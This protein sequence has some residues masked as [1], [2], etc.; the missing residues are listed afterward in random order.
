MPLSDAAIGRL[1]W[2]AIALAAFALLYALGPVLTP[3]FLAAILAYIFQ[4]LVL[5]LARR[6]PRALAVALVMLLEFLLLALLVLTVLPL[7]IKEI[8]LL[9]EQA[10]GF[11]DWLNHSL[12]PWIF[13]KTGVAVNFDAASLKRMLIDN[14]QGSEGLGM[15]LLNS[16]RMGGL[17]LV[18]IVAN[19]VLV[20]VVQFYLM[21]D[22]K[23]MIARVERLLPRPWQKD[24]IGF[25][26]EA[27]AALSQYL[28]GQVLVI[29]AM[30]LFYTGGLWVS[31]LAF[32][33]PI[34]MITGL[35]VFVPYL[36]AAI[37]L[38]LGTLAALM[39]FQEWS[40][41]LW[42]WLVFGIGMA[43][44]GNVVTPKL[45]GQRI[46]LHPIAVIFALLAFG[47]LFGFAGLL[48]ALPASAVL[49]VA[50]RKLRARYLQSALYTGQRK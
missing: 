19:V 50:L 44:E 17:G 11:F 20:P 6:L 1:S 24:T 18:G 46:G 3:F 25:V 8:S 23:S 41:I 16:V 31:G 29:L 9:A 2:S 22:W 45:V 5:W 38:T 27:D 12:A 33:L 15:K 10:P 32:F 37:G 4:P 43:I 47:Q 26:R 49:L 34:G 13:A 39:Q 14:L 40:G 42:V 36:G 7:F 35:L 30:S 28:H 48:L 21:R